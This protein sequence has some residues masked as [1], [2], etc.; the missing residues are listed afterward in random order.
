MMMMSLT[1]NC[2]VIL[3][4]ANEIG[5][6]VISSVCVSLCHQDISKSY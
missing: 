6:T 2:V 4:S 1:A 5:A 3:T